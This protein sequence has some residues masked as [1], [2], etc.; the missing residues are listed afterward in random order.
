LMV[1]QAAITLSAGVF[2]TVASSCNGTM[3]KY[4][5]ARFGVLTLTCLKK[6]IFVCLRDKVASAGASSRTKGYG[7]RYFIL[8]TESR[9]ESAPI[10]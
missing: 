6:Y 5:L 3:S 2:F 10:C 8:P 7:E 9:E 4:T 1:L